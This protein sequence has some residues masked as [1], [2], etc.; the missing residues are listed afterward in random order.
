MGQYYK[1]V[2]VD[3]QLYF[4]PREVGENG[5]KLM[6]W[7]YNGNEMVLALMN[8]LANEWKGDRVYVVG[9][10]AEADNSKEPCYEAVKALEGE[11]KLAENGEVNTI[12]G[13]ASEYYTNVSALTDKEDHGLRYI[14]NH[15]TKQFIDTAKCPIEWTWYSKDEKKV[16]VIKIAPISLLLAMGNDR[17]GGDFHEGCIGYE[18]VGSWC[19]SVQDIEVTAD[20]IEGLEY[21]EF[22]PNFTEKKVIVPYTDEEKVIREEMEKHA[23]LGEV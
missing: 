13:Y 14:Y 23:E 11:L 3:K 7:S 19:S 2:N 16:Y 9:D 5:A 6:E 8:L 4:T 1:V 21:E 17:G 20:K 15:K 18:Y 10:Y 12:C 22:A